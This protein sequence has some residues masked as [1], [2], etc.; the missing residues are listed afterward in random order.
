MQVEQG[1]CYK[2]LLSFPG[3]KPGSVKNCPFTPYVYT[4]IFNRA[5]VSEHSFQIHD[6]ILL[7]EDLEHILWVLLFLSI[8]HLVIS[9]FFYRFLFPCVEKNALLTSLFRYT[10]IITTATEVSYGKHVQLR[11]SLN[12][13]Y[14]G[15]VSYI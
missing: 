4:K 10:S 8:G 5:F 11:N 15:L 3:C 2:F 12:Y 7:L 6:T 1:Q 13:K 9:S 14:L